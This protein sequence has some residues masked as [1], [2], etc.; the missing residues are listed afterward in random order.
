LPTISNGLVIVTTTTIVTPFN[1]INAPSTLNRGRTL[2]KQGL[3]KTFLT[4]N[5]DSETHA[6][7]E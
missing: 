6:V 5:F 4:E 1:T 2:M 3:L 7:N